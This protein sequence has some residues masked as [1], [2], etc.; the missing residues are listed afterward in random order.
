MQI[1][2]ISNLETPTRL[3]SWLKSN[4]SLNY[5]LIQ[6]L[7]RKSDIKVN[8]QKISQNYKLSNGDIVTIY[9]TINTQKSITRKIDPQLHSQLLKQIKKSIV[10]KDNNIIVINKPYNV[11]T[12]G[13]SKIKISIDDILNDLKFDYTISP[14]LVHRLDKH[15]TGLLILA[16]TKQIAILLT[17]YFKNNS[18]EKKYLAVTIGTPKN[19]TGIIESQ[20]TK[21]GK[22]DFKNAITHYKITKSN[23]NTKMSLIEFK[24]VTGRTHQIRIHAAKDL[25]CPIISDTKYGQNTILAKIVENKLHL[26]A[27]EIKIKNVLGKNYSLKA[28]LPAHMQSTIKKFLLS[29]KTQDSV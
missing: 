1:F 17:K 5:T 2:K 10:F 9:T 13:G 21:L 7:I 12:Q 22:Q 29:Y 3:T 6:K 27:S 19:K 11:A 23:P 8:A 16:R 26:H 20:I 15:T 18:I 4:F 24:P 25:Q 14:R 28:P